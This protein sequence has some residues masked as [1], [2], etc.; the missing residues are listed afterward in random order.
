MTRVSSALFALLLAASLPVAAQKVSI[1]NQ[2]EASKQAT[3]QVLT[4]EAVENA[5]GK[6][7][8]GRAQV[9]FFRSS[10]SPGDAVSV[11]DAAGGLALIEL[12]PGMYYIASA[13]PGPRS[14]ATA[15]MGPFPLDLE[16][17][18]TYYVQAIRNKNG[19]TQLLLSSA[20][21]FARAAQH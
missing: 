17:G 20:D 11:R 13:I 1:E 3:A 10:K 8:A 2:G 15:D 7:P 12:D 16:P 21:K 19:R 9:V 18:R 4:A 6:A 5:V 14:Y